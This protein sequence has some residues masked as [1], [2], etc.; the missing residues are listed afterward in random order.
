MVSWGEQIFVTFPE[1]IPDISI[2]NTNSL[3][4]STASHAVFVSANSHSQ[5]QPP[6]SPALLA[7]QKLPSGERP[8]D[9]STSQ[10]R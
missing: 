5:T 7:R 6:Q 1:S 8:L 3:V 10:F 2:L 4:D 9:P